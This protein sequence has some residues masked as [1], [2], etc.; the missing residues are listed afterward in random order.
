MN[1]DFSSL[2]LPVEQLNNLADLGYTT[3]TPIQAKA[4]PLIL[5]GQDV[6]AKANEEKSG[7]MLAGIAA[8]ST[9]ERVAAKAVLADMTLEDLRKNP[10]VPYEEDD[11]TRAD[12][13]AVNEAV[14]DQIK[15]LTVGEFR[16]FLLSANDFDIAVFVH[17]R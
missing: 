6:L 1:T 4:L 14:Y 7:D 10:V 9:V 2:A 8:Q 12:Q 17:R 3:M 15:S 13:D 5:Q 11:V 16:E